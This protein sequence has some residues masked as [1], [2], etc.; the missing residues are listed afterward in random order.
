M[1]SNCMNMFVERLQEQSVGRTVHRAYFFKLKK[2]D[3]YFW[4]LEG[5]CKASTKLDHKGLQRIT[6]SSPELHF[7]DRRRGHCELI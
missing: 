1:H 2:A 3:L 5:D 4:K 6:I 7:D